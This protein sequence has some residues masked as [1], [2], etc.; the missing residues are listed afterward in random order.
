ML[1]I[2]PVALPVCAIMKKETETIGGV[3]EMDRKFLNVIVVSI[4]LMV[5]FACGQKKVEPT[6]EIQKSIVIDSV[7]HNGQIIKKEGVSFVDVEFIISHPKFQNLNEDFGL[8]PFCNIVRETTYIAIQD[9]N[10]TVYVIGGYDANTN[11]DNMFHVYDRTH[12]VKNKKDEKYILGIVR[13]VFAIP[14]KYKNNKIYLR[15]FNKGN[16][17]FASHDQASGDMTYS[18]D[19]PDDVWFEYEINK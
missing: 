11:P 7:E 5:F 17:G 12:L 6:V 4:I 1:A 2:I 14:E 3:K 13:Y 10:R 18:Y 8:E 16:F 15:I 19:E 9:D